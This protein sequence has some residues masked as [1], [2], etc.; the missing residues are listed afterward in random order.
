MLKTG[1]VIGVSI[2]TVILVLLLA[3]I[4][5]N[6]DKHTR[7]IVIQI[8][9][10]LA[11][12]I[13]YMAYF[14]SNDFRMKVIF[15][16]LV[17]LVEIWLW[18]VF[19][20]YVYE[21][22]HS[23][24]K[25]NEKLNMLSIGSIVLDNVFILINMF[26]GMF[27]SFDK[28]VEIED[29]IW[30]QPQWTWLTVIHLVGCVFM[31]LS[32]VVIM[33]RKAI[34]VARVYRLRY[35]VGIAMFALGTAFVLAGRLAFGNSHLFS[36]I[37]L[38]AG[39]MGNY[40][41]YFHYPILRANQM[42]TYA[43][44]HMADP[45]LMFDYNDH[46][47]VYNT[48]AERLVKV[49]PYYELSDFIKEN[50][51]HFNV[52]KHE[53]R[54]GKAREFTRTK[55]F[56]ARTYLIYGQELWDHKDR[57]VGTLIVYTD[58]TGQERLKDEATLYAT[59]DQLTGLWNRDYFFEIAE[60]TILENPNEEFVMLASD[61][62]HFKLF[63]EILGTDMGDDLLLAFA[64]AYREHYKRMWVFSR[65]AADRFALLLPKA[66][67][68]E[69]GLVKIVQEVLERKSYSLK[70]HCYIGVYEVTD[71]S[72]NVESMYDRAYMAVEAMKGDLHKFIAYYDEE[73]LNERI[74]ETTTLD[75]LDRALLNDEF[76]IYLQPQID[77]RDNKVVSAEALIRW[78]KPGRGI[79]SPGE[80]IPIF[81]NNGMIAKLDYYVW[82]LACRQ[83]AKWKRE[84]F[85]NRSISV[86]ISAKD[87]YLTDL[88]ESIVGLVEKYDIDPENL[89]L[90]ITETAFV[91]DIKKQ[92][93]LVNKLQNYGFVIEID[94]FGSGYSSLHNLKE[95]KADML[96]M[97]LKFFEK[98]EE[99]NRAEKI[100][101]SVIRLA[102][103]LGMPV[104]AE[105]VEEAN[106][107]MML[108]EAGCQ[109]VQGYYY[110]KPM[111]VENFEAF[112]STRVY[113]DIKEIIEEVKSE[114]I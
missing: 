48:A 84:G 67:F 12:N 99:G 64:Q 24:R 95:I 47:Q 27:F 58:I 88:Y 51:L 17:M 112:L 81:E 90:E 43:I 8:L 98:T 31:G 77:I 100:V 97:D 89:K 59:R 83:L 106:E 75:D 19:L 26:T 2:I 45:V 22:F 76:V 114:C 34:T 108:K 52:D 74:H 49:Q 16:D 23:W 20:R 40:N 18:Y 93:A 86:N 56:N 85:G 33:V 78:D 70:A 60:K 53:K 5:Q 101:T 37:F 11:I 14:L 82:E 113:G 15:Y 3:Q 96:K 80:F 65:I 13:L 110:A 36:V 102:N 50:E 46:L 7:G 57:F 39:I 62:Y 10:G 55:I 107:V 92:M 68:N 6:K 4:V 69:E 35:I 104:I 25:N 38:S 79:V 63:N 105:G 71:K 28:I 42:K 91:L 9:L 61:I 54:N 109:I 41:L 30:V 1:I 73:I 72:L 32:V 29:C 21:R 44:N 111:S 87:F 103:D 94:D 66:D